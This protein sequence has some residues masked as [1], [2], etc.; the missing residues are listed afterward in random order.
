MTRCLN[1]HSFKVSS[2]VGKEAG[3]QTDH[4]QRWPGL[5]ATIRDKQGH[6]HRG[7]R[8]LGW[9]WGVEEDEV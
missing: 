4:A 7:R 2:G 8:G 1:K 5:V 6:L 9:G 3:G